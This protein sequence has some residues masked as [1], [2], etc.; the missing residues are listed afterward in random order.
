MGA[1]RRLLCPLCSLSPGTGVPG[2]GL[3]A[4]SSLSH[5]EAPGKGMS[6]ECGYICMDQAFTLES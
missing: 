6:V 5:G 1:K 4:C 3:F 2:E